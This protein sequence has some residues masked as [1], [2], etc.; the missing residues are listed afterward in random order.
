MHFTEKVQNSLYY[1]AEAA[2]HIKAIE[3]EI[4]T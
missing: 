3:Q 2:K 1:L 4:N